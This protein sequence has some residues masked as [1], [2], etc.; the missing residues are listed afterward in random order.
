MPYGVCFADSGAWLRLF[1][2]K[3]GGVE[4]TIFCEDS[5]GGFGAVDCA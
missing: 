4:E 2:V 3:R 5:Q 1:L